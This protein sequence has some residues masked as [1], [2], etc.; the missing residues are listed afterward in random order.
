[1]VKTAPIS[2]AHQLKCMEVWGGN[3]AIDSAI[4]APG[5]DAYIF[6]RP[7][8]GDERGGDV[9]YVSMCMA[10][11]IARFA[12]ADVS[13]HGASVDGFARTL[14]SLMRKHINTPDQS[15]FVRALNDEFVRQSRA[16]VFATALLASYFAPEQRLI[17]SNA[18]HPRPLWRRASTGEWAMLTEEAGANVERPGANL[19]LGVIEPTEYRQFAVSLERGDFVLIY[20]DALIEAKNSAGRMLGEQG[21]VE[22]ARSLD[23]AD[24]PSFIGAL[25]R[26][27]DEFAEGSEPEDDETL[28]LLAATGAPPKRPGLG[29]RLGAVGRMLGIGA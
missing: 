28:L 2:E 5:L 24:A 26:G 29:E 15:R 16:G 7:H 23:G 20:T 6:S 25:R 19:P 18:G 27:I 1:M 8:A 13:G 9:H 3:R 14:R 22:I 10:G 12:V 21:L 11:C 17:V 4:S